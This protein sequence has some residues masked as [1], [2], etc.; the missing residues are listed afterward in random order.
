MPSGLALLFLFAA[1]NCPAPARAEHESIRWVDGSFEAFSRGSWEAADLYVTRAGAVKTVNRY[2]LNGDGYLDLVFNSTHDSVFIIEPTCISVAHGQR[3]A[4]ALSVPA[5]GTR[6]VVVADLNHDGYPDAVFMPNFAYGTTG[7]RFL[8]VFW[9][10]PDGWSGSRHTDLFTMDAR[11]IAVADLNHDGWP[12]IVVLNGMRWATPDGPEAT[13]RIYWG[14]AQGFSHEN[15]RDMVVPQTADMK[16]ADLDM[17]R[18]QLT[19]PPDAP[20]AVD[21]K[22]ADLDGDGRPDLIVLQSMPWP[23]LLIYWNDPSGLSKPSRIDLGSPTDRLAVLDPPAEQLGLIYRRPDGRPD[24]VVN[25]GGR[26]VTRDVTTGGEK[27]PSSGAIVSPDM[28][29]LPAGEEKR[30]WQSPRTIQAPPSSTFIVADLNQDGYP[31]LILCDRAAPQDSVHILWGDAGGRFNQKPM[32]TLPLAYV[33]ALAVE[34]IDGDGHPDLV[35]GVAQS[36]DTTRAKSHVLFGDGRGGFRDDLT[37]D[38]AGVAGVG[39]VKDA[40]QTRI[41]FCNEHASRTHEDVPAFVYWGGPHGFSPEKVSRYSIRSGYICAAADLNDDGYPDLVL[42]STVHAVAEWHPGA[43]YNILWGGPD[44]LK[45]DRRTVLNKEYGVGSFCIADVDRDGYLDLIGRYKTGLNQPDESTGGLVIC[46]GG[47]KGFERRQ[48]LSVG[49]NYDGQVLVADFNKDGY[50]DIA[51]TR[52]ETNQVTIFYGSAHGFSASNQSSAPQV[53]ACDFNA[54]DLNHDGWLDL[55]VS[56][57]ALPDDRENFDY[58]TT[59]F[60]GGPDGIRQ[61]NSQRLPARGGMGTIVADFDGDGYLDIFTPSYHS[62]FTRESTAAKLF[63]GSPTGFSDLNCTDLM[64]DAGSS[65][66]AADFNGD[67]R[68]D[69]VVDCH[70]RDGDHRTN[71]LVFYGDGARFTKSIPQKLPTAGVHYMYRSDVGSIYD[72]SYR[73]SYTSS[74]FTLNR[75][76][77]KGAFD[78]QAETPGKTRLE[79]SW[80]SAA[81]QQDLA[82]RPWQIYSENAFRLSS[83]DRYLQYRAVFVSDNGDRY[84]VLKRVEV[85]LD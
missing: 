29:V 79:I 8:S 3:S 23:S 47:P 65:A 67:G 75:A 28:I 1:V 57:Y 33:S 41:I 54:A 6:R 32:T 48:V 7:R 40:E 16:V 71:S 2:D 70:T 12:D 76:C 9:G 22:V 27:T 10:G 52:E 62:N 64:Q 55:V 49:Q 77:I 31:D 34:D 68:M 44:G 83:S 42:L 37:A 60:W 19:A 35:A 74:V 69:L 63:W 36:A 50:P 18:W 26:A 4:Q 61:S 84:P 11:A 15:H 39:V 24:L 5:L 59:I 51:M 25:C 72:R 80:R 85:T 82:T 30:T 46:Y 43:G 66:M 13:V 14:S 20:Q 81:S 17:S 58:G 45:D 78:V 53:S 38:T 73:K 21:M 56:S